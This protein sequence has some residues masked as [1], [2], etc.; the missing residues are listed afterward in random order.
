MDKL[1]TESSGNSSDDGTVG[2]K[3]VQKSEKNCIV[4]QIMEIESLPKLYLVAKQQHLQIILKHLQQFSQ[5]TVLISESTYIWFFCQQFP[6][7]LGVV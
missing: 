3:T 6:V 7:L 2:D 5:Q 1:L 4:Y